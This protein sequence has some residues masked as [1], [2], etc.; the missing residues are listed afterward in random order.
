MPGSFF[1]CDQTLVFTDLFLC[2]KL[3]LQTLVSTLGVLELNRKGSV[4]PRGTVRTLVWSSFLWSGVSLPPSLPWCLAKSINSHSVSPEVIPPNCY[5]AGRGESPDGGEDAS[6]FHTILLF[7]WLIEVW[8][9]I[10][11]LSIRWAI[12]QNKKAKLLYTYLSTN[13]ILKSKLQNSK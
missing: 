11:G 1:I 9:I 6:G 4:E 13:W 3:F 7:S 2:S 5:R 10:W 8:L 12:S